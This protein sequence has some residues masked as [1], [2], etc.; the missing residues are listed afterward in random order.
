MY[1]KILYMA[2]C[3]GRCRYPPV[4]FW[5][6]KYY[7]IMSTA[8]VKNLMRC[9][10]NSDKIVGEAFRLPLPLRPWR[11]FFKI[12]DLVRMPA[13]AERGQGKEAFRLPKNRDDVGIV[14][15]ADSGLRL[16]CRG[17]VPSPP[18][19]A[20]PLKRDGQPVPYACHS[21]QVKP[22]KNRIC[23]DYYSDKT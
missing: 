10:Y 21:E 15:Y 7:V 23:C 8:G 16:P 4:Y 14:P 6:S 12:A 9:N 1:G 19:T 22:V 17:G 18:V 3:R 20:S 5:Q 2:N 13:A 11:Q